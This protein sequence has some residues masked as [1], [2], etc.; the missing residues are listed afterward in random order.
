MVCLY[1]S[2]KT[3]VINSRAQKRLNRVWRRRQCLACGAVFTTEEALDYGGSIV[4][5][6]EATQEAA[7][8]RHTPTA[9]FQRDK[10]YVSILKALGHRSTAVQDATALCDTI[11]AKLLPQAVEATLTPQL[12]IT[13]TYDT[14]RRFDTAAAVQYRAYHP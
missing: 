12:I 10:L 8:S 13:V 11:I 6:P 14:L 9:P 5:R 3:Q 1:C 2:G 7:R 4:V